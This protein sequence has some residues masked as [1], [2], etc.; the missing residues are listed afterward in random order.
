MPSI[1]LFSPADFGQAAPAAVGT[2][3]VVSTGDV[4][5]FSDDDPL[6]NDATADPDSPDEPGA[7]QYLTEDLV[8]DGVVEGTT[9][10]II[11]NAAEATVVNDTTGETGRLLYVT[12]GGTAVTDFVSYATTIPLRPGDSFTISG[13]SFTGVEAYADIVPCFHA[14]TMIMTDSGEVPVERL[15]VGSLIRTA[16]HCLQP[17]R[18][19]GTRHLSWQEVAAKP[20]LRPIRISAGALGDGLP[21]RDL[22][23]SPQHR[24]LVRSKIA[25]RMAGVPEVL[26]AAKHLCGMPGIA[27]AE[28]VAA[29]VYVHF[30]MDRHE[31]VFA[32]SAASESLH[33]G[34][35]A[36]RSVGP[37]ARDEIFAIFPELRDRAYR[38]VPARPLIGGRVGRNLA[39][40]HAA[41]SRSLLQA[42]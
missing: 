36:L 6:F 3:T 4:A 11:Y 32:E 18:W 29:P 7:L 27:V 42:R 20:A 5:R 34:A 31:V 17:I 22:V 25:Q 26:V 14:G 40:R 24:I 21:A 15:D 38:P 2:Y 23:V 39:R 37:A 30:L 35:E 28:D 16:D 12:V 41:N 13:F 1:Y 19:I 8:I 10:Q 33:T 9:G